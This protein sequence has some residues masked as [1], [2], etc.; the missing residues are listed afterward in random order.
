MIFLPKLVQVCVA[1][2]SEFIHGPSSADTNLV[3]APVVLLV[4][5][6]HQI[7]AVGRRVKRTCDVIHSM[8]IGRTWNLL[9]IQNTPSQPQRAI[10]KN[11]GMPKS[12]LV[13]YSDN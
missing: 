13:W 2:Q 10:S 11:N 7:I 5:E 3:L 12:E 6:L 8:I 9:L 4:K 1:F